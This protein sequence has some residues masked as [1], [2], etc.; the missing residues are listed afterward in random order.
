MRNRRAF[1]DPAAARTHVGRST[2]D[3]SRRRS[4]PSRHRK[5]GRCLRVE[6]RPGCRGCWERFLAQSSPPYCGL[7]T[8]AMVLST[9]L[10]PNERWRGGWRWRGHPPIQLLYAGGGAFPPTP[11]PPPPRPQLTPPS[12]PTPTPTPPPPH[13]PPP[14]I[15]PPAR[16]GS[17]LRQPR[18]RRLPLTRSRAPAPPPSGGRRTMDQLAAMGALPDANIETVRATDTVGTTRTAVM[19]AVATDR[20]PF[21][22]GSFARAPLNQTGDGH[23]ADCWMCAPLGHP[24]AALTTPYPPCPPPTPTPPPRPPPTP[25]AP[26]KLPAATSPPDPP[27]SPSPRPRRRPGLGPAMC[28]T[29]RASSLPVRAAPAPVRGHAPLDP[30]TGKSRGYQWVAPPPRPSPRRSRSGRALRRQRRR[31]LPGVGDTKGLLSG[32]A[33]ALA[34]HRPSYCGAECQ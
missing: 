17:P 16:R 21:L 30:V 5:V 7:T 4:F 23:F 33:P 19:R 26:T 3:S 2:S 22:V 1:S 32:V 12:T 13:L 25:L 11:P 18:V 15:R 9:C 10:D 24:S 28:S 6:W 29:S 34:I 8:L 14:K 20:A 31:P 27:L